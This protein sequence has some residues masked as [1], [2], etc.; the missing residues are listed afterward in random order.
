MIEVL[1][2]TYAHAWSAVIYG[3]RGKDEKEASRR[4]IVSTDRVAVLGISLNTTEME[5][6]IKEKQEKQEKEK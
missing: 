5:T 2:L 1:L 4:S 6:V 3:E